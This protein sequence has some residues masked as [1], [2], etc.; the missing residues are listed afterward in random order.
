MTTC[1][2]FYEGVLRDARDRPIMEG[3][4]LAQ[5]LAGG[6]R[7]VVATSGTREA[8]ERDLRTEHLLDQIVDVLD[9]TQGLPPT[10]LWQRQIEVARHRAPITWLVSADPDVVEWAVEH[11]VLSL[12]FAHPRLSG[13]ARRPETGNRSWEQLVEELEAR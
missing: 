7:L 3:F 4:R 1:L 13:P 9:K 2:C 5:T 6:T 8:V 10:P 12:F 11:G